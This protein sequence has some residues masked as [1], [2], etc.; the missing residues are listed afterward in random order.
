MEDKASQ[1]SDQLFEINFNT[2]LGERERERERKKTRKIAKKKKTGKI[3]K[4]E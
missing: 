2:T 4:E 1:N 3:K